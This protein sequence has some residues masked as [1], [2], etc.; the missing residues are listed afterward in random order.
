MTGWGLTGELE[1]GAT[2]QVNKY[3]TVQLTPFN[4]NDPFFGTIKL[5]ILSRYLPLDFN[6]APSNL[7]VCTHF[8]IAYQ[9]GLAGPATDWKFV[10]KSENEA[11]KKVNLLPEPIEG[12]YFFL[13]SLVEMSIPVPL[14]VKEFLKG[15]APV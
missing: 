8:H 4:L 9:W 2:A 13:V 1:N 3:I 11:V 7:Q 12:T 6:L 10:L 15:I 14:F 5:F